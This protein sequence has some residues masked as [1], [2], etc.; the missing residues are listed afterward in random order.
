M[1][2]LTGG[3]PR[4]SRK[5]GPG[6]PLEGPGR[7]CPGFRGFSAAPQSFFRDSASTLSMASM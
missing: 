2:H 7:V 4:V 6:G 5:A 1:G 3:V